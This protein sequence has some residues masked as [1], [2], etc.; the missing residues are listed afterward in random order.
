MMRKVRPLRME[1]GVA[2]VPLTKG[3]EAAIDAADAPLVAAFNWY[4][5]VNGR[6]VY[7]HRKS[8]RRDGKQSAIVLHRVVVSAPDGMHVDHIDGDGLNNRRANL[9]LA[10]NAENCRNARLS[11]ASTSGFKGVSWSKAHCKWQAQIAPPGG[12]KHLGYFECPEAAHAVYAKAAVQ[13]F[14]Q[15]AR[16]S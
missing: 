4:A 7:A 14:G 8:P 3:Y 2:Y 6:T 1:G 12:R 15:F 11:K 13:F 5:M 16:K 10:T 9:R